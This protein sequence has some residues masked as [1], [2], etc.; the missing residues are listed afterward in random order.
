MKENRPKS[1]WPVI[2]LI[3][4]ILGA[5][6]YFFVWE[7]GSQVNTPSQT[8]P[9]TSENTNPRP[10]VIPPG[11]Q[12]EF[13]D[14]VSTPPPAPPKKITLSGKYSYSEDT[15]SSVVGKV[16]FVP[17]QV[18]SGVGKQF[19]FNNQDEVFAIF[20]L[21]RGFSDGSKQCTVSAK[22]SIEI[23]G[24]TKFTSDVGGYDSATLTKVTSKGAQSFSACQK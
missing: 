7:K 4:L 14:E 21:Q 9:S 13:G 12:G 10:S 16:C 18:V 11:I 5:L 24:Y 17:D 15:K 2:I 6:G 1:K 22:A 20:G 8:T 23:Q 3:I 19:C